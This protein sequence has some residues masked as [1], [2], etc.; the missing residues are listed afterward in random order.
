MSIEDVNA[1]YDLSEAE[2]NSL[3][4]I[5]RRETP[6]FVTRSRLHEDLVEFAENIHRT[7]ANNE[8]SH[9]G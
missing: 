3:V 6:N 5:Y 7:R 2:S 4:E 9:P 8:S 1:E